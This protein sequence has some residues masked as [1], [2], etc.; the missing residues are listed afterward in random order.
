MP[1]RKLMPEVL[2]THSHEIL[3]AIAGGH[4]INFMVVPLVRLNQFRWSFTLPPAINNR[5]WFLLRFYFAT[6]A[7]LPEHHLCLATAYAKLALDLIHRFVEVEPFHHLV[8]FVSSASDAQP[9]DNIP[10]PRKIPVGIPFI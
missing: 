6:G 1:R 7:P 10:D 8:I 5:I 3:A 4:H 9:L 2:F